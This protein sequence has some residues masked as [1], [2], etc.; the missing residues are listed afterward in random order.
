MI[1]LVRQLTSTRDLAVAQNLSYKAK[2]NQPGKVFAR[3]VTQ[4]NRLAVQF[5]QK[6]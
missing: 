5:A 4:L 6:G 2:L 3:K 1:P